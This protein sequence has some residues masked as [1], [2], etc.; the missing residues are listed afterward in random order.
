MVNIPKDKIELLISLLSNMLVDDQ[1][2]ETVTDT[3]KKIQKEPKIKQKK[4]PVKANGTRDNKFLSMPER[5]LHKEDVQIDKMLQKVP[6]V[7]RNRKTSFL[8]V[9]CRVCGKKEKISASLLFEA[10]DRYKCNKCS[11]NPG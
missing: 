8:D 3:P 10:I 1:P 2:Q 4:G 7:S 6:P 11:I 5:N 9:C